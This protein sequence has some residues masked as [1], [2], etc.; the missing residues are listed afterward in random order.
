MEVSDQRHA[1]AASP[2]GKSTGTHGKRGWMG[3]KAGRDGC[4]EEEPLD[5]NGVRAPDRPARSGSL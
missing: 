5:P 4:V 2:P 1:P 3:P